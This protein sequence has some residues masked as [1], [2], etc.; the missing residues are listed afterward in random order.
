M[1]PNELL[2][3][4]E[5]LHIKFSCIPDGFG[6]MGCEW[7]ENCQKVTSVF[8][9]SFSVYY[10]YFICL[11]KGFKENISFVMYKL[12]KVHVQSLYERHEQIGRFLQKL[13][14]KRIKHS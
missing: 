9:V 4:N 10:Y 12:F 5:L 13:H 1:C 3:P 11:K 8:H 2:R 7:F 6:S 14:L